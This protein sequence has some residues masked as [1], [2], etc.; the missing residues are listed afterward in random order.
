MKQRGYLEHEMIFKL[1]EVCVLREI[2]IAFINYWTS[3]AEICIEPLSVLVS[4]G[5][6]LENLQQICTLHQVQ[7]NAFATNNATIFAKNMQEYENI[8]SYDELSIVDQISKQ[9]E[10]LPN[11]KV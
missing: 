6:D 11:F 7:D 4:G 9:I 5:L 3:D 2:Q 8:A 1:N 10:T